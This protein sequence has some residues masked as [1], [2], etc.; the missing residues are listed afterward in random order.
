MYEFTPNDVYHLAIYSSGSSRP[1]VCKQADHSL[2]YCIIVEPY[3]I[4]G[5][6]YNTIK[7]SARMDE[8]C[9]TVVPD[10]DAKRNEGWMIVLA[11][12]VILV[13]IWLVLLL[14]LLVWL[15]LS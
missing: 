6:G 14:L 11:V 8:K 4:H 2:D 13:I 7:P 9:L 15:V 1:D 10:K 12:V 5:N 3:A